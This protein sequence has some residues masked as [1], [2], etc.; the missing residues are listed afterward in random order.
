[1]YTHPPLKCLKEISIPMLPFQIIVEFNGLCAL[2]IVNANTKKAI[3]SFDLI[4]ILFFCLFVYLLLSFSFFF[5]GGGGA[6]VVM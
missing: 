1:M 3:V 2:Y 6:G 4:F 5:D